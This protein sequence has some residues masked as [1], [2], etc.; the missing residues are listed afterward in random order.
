MSKKNKNKNKNGM[1]PF[2][3][4]HPAEVQDSKPKIEIPAVK[5]TVTVAEKDELKSDEEHAKEVRGW[6]DEAQEYVDAK[7]KEADDYLAAKQKEI[8]DLKAE[9]ETRISQAVEDAKKKAEDEV[10]ESSRQIIDEAEKEANEKK[11]GLAERESA[12]H[13]SEQSLLKEKADLESAKI[14]YKNE[15]YKEISKAIDDLKKEKE[16]LQAELDALRVESAKKDASISSL[17]GTNQG[18]AE[19]LNQSKNASKDATIYKH[20]LEE[21]ES[22][23]KTAESISGDRLKE[24]EGLKR[25]IMLYGDNPEKAMEENAALQ[26]RIKDLE[27]LLADQPGA[28]ELKELRG[29]KAEY[30]KILNENAQLKTQINALINE[31]TQIKVNIDDMENYRRSIKMLTLQKNELQAELERNISLYQGSTEKIF[32]TLSEI[33][34]DIPQSYPSRAYNLKDICAQFRSYL[35][36]RDTNPLYYNERQIRTFIAGFAASRLTILEGLSGTGKSSLPMAFQD[37]M[38][39]ITE[40]VPVQSA[41]KDR[42]DLLGFY[43]DF[44]KQYKETAFLKAL[45][46]ASHDP[47][48]IHIIVLDEMNLS[49]IEYYFADLLSVLEKPKQD[50]WKI[51]LISDYSSVSQNSQAWPKLIHEGSLQIMPNT[52]FV[53]TANKDDSTF[54]ITDK[55]YDRAVVLNFD[56]KGQKDDSLRYCSPIKINSD[57][58]NQLLSRASHFQGGDSDALRYQKMIDFLDQQVIQLFSITFGNRIANQLDVFVPAYKACGGTVDEA[59]D[60]MFSRK[61]LRKLEGLYDDKTKENLSLLKAEIQDAYGKNSLPITVETLDK[62]IN[63]IG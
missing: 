24:L 17:K 27:D 33:D 21:A 48:N 35:A 39:S 49:R 13:D 45:Y 58:F 50:D 51:E 10:K 20:K 53:G 63:R 16:Q 29:I 56:K 15:I 7:K 26:K 44:K 41:W 38:G 4:P 22:D 12:L 37:F 5:A 18:I 9:E 40:V 34:K 3:G 52:W 2:M 59:V 55:V 19:A 11:A 14:G 43:N 36:N 47:D 6:L 28:E 42:N 30:D 31:N 1:P 32:P 8:D 25:Q 46:R 61:V 57:D 62:M 54:T 23:L 60:I